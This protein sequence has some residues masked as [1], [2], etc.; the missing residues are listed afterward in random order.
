MCLHGNETILME[1]KNKSMA[2]GTALHVGVGGGMIV[3]SATEE[4]AASVENDRE[5]VSRH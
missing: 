3:T 4:H 5:T 1:I 2:S